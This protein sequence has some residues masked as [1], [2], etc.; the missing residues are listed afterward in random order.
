MRYAGYVPGFSLDAV[1]ISSS[2]MCTY[3]YIESR[4]NDR[5]ARPFGS[6]LNGIFRPFT[7]PLKY[8]NDIGVHIGEHVQCP[9]YAMFTFCSQF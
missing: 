4:N 5:T 6:P 3:I 8:T 7:A 2:S 9:V 1:V